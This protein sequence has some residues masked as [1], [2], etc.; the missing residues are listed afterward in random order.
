M[1]IRLWL[2]VG[3]SPSPVAPF[4]SGL[5]VGAS[6]RPEERNLTR[7]SSLAVQTEPTYKGWISRGTLA[8]SWRIAQAVQAVISCFGGF[9]GEGERSRSQF[10]FWRCFCGAGTEDT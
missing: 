5:C 1:E 4:P 2:H 3:K 10:F 7:I 6:G 9:S 8:A